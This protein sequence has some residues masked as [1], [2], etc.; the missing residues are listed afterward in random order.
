MLHIPRV[1]V[2]KVMQDLYHQQYCGIVDVPVA[3]RPFQE[4]E[5]LYGSYTLGHD[6]ERPTWL[7]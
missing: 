6:P 5:P 7:N 3:F 2:H 4:A 1:L